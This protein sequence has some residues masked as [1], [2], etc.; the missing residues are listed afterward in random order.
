MPY[1]NVQRVYDTL[2]HNSTEETSK[3]TMI[4]EIFQFLFKLPDHDTSKNFVMISH[5]LM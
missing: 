4:N 3:R 5:Y 1:N 2:I